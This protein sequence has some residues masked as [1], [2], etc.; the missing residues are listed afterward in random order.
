[1][2]RRRL[3]LQLCDEIAYGYPDPWWPQDRAAT[4]AR[5]NGLTV[6]QGEALGRYIEL[7]TEVAA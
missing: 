4:K 5:T 2:T 7:V 1:M 3:F 6:A